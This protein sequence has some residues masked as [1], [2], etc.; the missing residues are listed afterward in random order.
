MLGN[1]LDEYVR[2]EENVL[3]PAIESLMSD[4]ELDWL[5]GV[6]EE[7]EKKSSPSHTE[8]SCL[9]CGGTDVNPLN[10]DVIT[11]APV[12]NLVNPQFASRRWGVVGLR[13]RQESEKNKP[14]VAE[15]A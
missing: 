13:V 8:T 11:I 5:A 7:I 1:A 3:F 15:G 12:K 6:T 4:E 9:C 10:C 14:V 2:W